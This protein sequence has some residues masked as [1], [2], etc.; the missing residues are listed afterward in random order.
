MVRHTRK[1]KGAAY[2]GQGSFGCTF[3]PALACEG[4]GPRAANSISKLM[5]EGQADKE[6]QLHDIFVGI[7][8]TQKHFIY[9][10]RMCRPDVTRIRVS[11]RI[12]QC[13]LMK[14]N[15]DPSLAQPVRRTFHRNLHNAKI[16]EYPDGGTDLLRFQMKTN[17]VYQYFKGFENLLE[18]LVI[19]HEAGY[20]H[21]DIKHENITVKVSDPNASR[22]R[23]LHMRFIDYGFLSNG[24][25]LYGNFHP[26]TFER[27]YFVWPFDFLFLGIRTL[28]DEQKVRDPANLVRYI[29]RY[30]ENMLQSYPPPNLPDSIVEELDTIS[31]AKIIEIFEAFK[32]LKEQGKCSPPKPFGERED[33]GF[34][35]I[36]E[37]GCSERGCCWDPH[38]DPNPE[39]TPYCY[40]PPPEATYQKAFLEKYLS[41]VDIYSLGMLMG[42]EFIRQ[43]QLIKRSPVYIEFLGGAPTFED[44]AWI[45]ELKRDIAMPFFA[46][47]EKMIKMDF[48]ERISAAAALEEYRLIL[49][50]MERLLTR[51]KIERYFIL[52]STMDPTDGG[53]KK[54]TRKRKY[55]SSNR[56]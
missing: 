37:R 29:N 45:D 4:N 5:Q 7:D 16:I 24:T 46:L 11:N 25:T 54:K 42:C 31:N 12:S 13:D 52:Y 41:T 2:I 34:F 40:R 17:L 23:T 14:G 44:A 56:R 38:P 53:G 21:L 48:R 1:Q 30:G 43:L 22:R 6:Y 33:C 8:P 55:R 26:S 51:E 3:R 10:R 15:S 20:A 19:L 9:P 35:G 18:G 47:I 32:Q 27:M 28:A 39:S 36:D 49:P 50:A